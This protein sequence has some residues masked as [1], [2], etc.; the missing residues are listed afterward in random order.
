MNII[1]SNA[2]L[3]YL[4]K[5]HKKSFH[6]ISW[7]LMAHGKLHDL[8]PVSCLPSSG[9]PVQCQLFRCIQNLALSCQ[10]ILDFLQELYVHVKMYFSSERCPNQ[11]YSVLSRLKQRVRC[12]LL[13]LHSCSQKI[14]HIHP[15]SDSSWHEQRCPKENQ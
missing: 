7:S 5:L 1:L 9:I 11:I 15:H 2:A 4:H 8:C 13:M 3:I 6:Y 14:I 12:P 10:W